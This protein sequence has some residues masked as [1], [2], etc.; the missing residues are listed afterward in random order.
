MRRI[1]IT[2]DDIKSMVNNAIDAMSDE[3]ADIKYPNDFE[4][5]GESDADERMD[6]FYR[7]I[8]ELATEGI[9]CFK[10]IKEMISEDEYGK[11]NSDKLK[12]TLEKINKI[13]DTLDD[14]V[15]DYG[16]E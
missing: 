6:M 11:A 9:L 7:A 14:F 1:S 13:C 5:T 16:R 15:R 3:V 12:K 8:E 10:K 2:E 4:F